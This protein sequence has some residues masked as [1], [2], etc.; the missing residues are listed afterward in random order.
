MAASAPA[1]PKASDNDVLMNAFVEKM[2]M[3]TRC[4]K[5]CD[6]I[7]QKTPWEPDAHKKV[8]SSIEWV[9]RFE[10]RPEMRQTGARGEVVQSVGEL[11]RMAGEVKPR[12]DEVLRNV[13]E[14]CGV[15][16]AMVLTVPLKSKERLVE[17]LSKY[18]ARHGDQPK[19]QPPVSWVFDVVRGSL[20]ARTAEQ[21]MDLMETLRAREAVELMKGTE[22][23]WEISRVKNRFDKAL[24]HGYR[25]LLV[26]IR[27]RVDQSWHVCE[28]QIH[29]AKLWE[30]NVVFGMHRLYEYL[31]PYFNL[32]M[33]GPDARKKSKDLVALL[34]SWKLARNAR[35]AERLSVATNMH[36]TLVAWF[37]KRCTRQTRGK[38]L[39]CPVLQT[40]KDDL[41]LLQ[42]IGLLQPLVFVSEEILLQLEESLKSKKSVKYALALAETGRTLFQVSKGTKLNES[43]QYCRDAL[44][45]VEEITGAAEDNSA[46]LCPILTV[47]VEILLVKGEFQEAG[48]TACRIVAMQE[49]MDL[50]P[51]HPSRAVPARH[52]AAYLKSHGRDAEAIPVLENCLQISEQALGADHPQCARVLHSLVDCLVTTRQTP[53][54]LASLKRL[55]ETYASNYGGDGYP[56]NATN[57][58]LFGN[59][60]LAK[61]QHEEALA[62]LE[63]SLETSQALHGDEN[64]V[65]SK[66]MVAIGQVHIKMGN[67][68][69]GEERIRSA[70]EIDE[71][72]FGA[73]SLRSV[74]TQVELAMCM[75]EVG[76]FEQA[77]RL[78]D[79]AIPII[80]EEAGETSLDMGNV[81]CAQAD[82]LKQ[83][84]LFDDAQSKLD[85]C[86]RI[87]EMHLGSCDPKT[88]A[89][90]RSIAELLYI[91]GFSDEGSRY[92]RKVQE[93]T[94]EEDEVADRISEGDEDEHAES[95]L[96]DSNE[97]GEIDASSNN[98]PEVSRQ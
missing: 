17:K 14:R 32:G 21:I 57:L 8:A 71:K 20:I 25:D 70:L 5:E 79:E 98:F 36:Q 77:A 4:R 49:K 24:V 37:T 58:S 12:F 46:A 26:S 95:E 9:D 65:V 82:L 80:R 75:R 19:M 93:I 72:L 45:I 83:Q 62:A 18:Q 84:G 42:V 97:A 31:R 55:C 41:L 38:V 47:L 92:M 85:L 34:E 1:V 7:W 52:M 11:Y 89:A 94:G 29:T 33:N 40:C 88:V 35:G 96:G 56:G 50:P 68:I 78:L 91:M 74:R 87:Y 90:M 13:G 61:G 48:R 15:K 27:F 39:K 69:M 6:E 2:D 66:T 30:Y 59:L 64:E 16:P 67:P 22:R 81:L 10:S 53:E 43:E 23:G 3:F 60:L 51:N 28:L 76:D 73:L 86:I 54:A 63:K 44:A